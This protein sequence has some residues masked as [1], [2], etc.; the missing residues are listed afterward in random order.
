M[1]AC[2]PIPAPTPPWLLA[3][4]PRSPGGYDCAVRNSCPAL[5]TAC[6]L[7]YY[8]ASYLGHPD[9]AALDRAFKATVG[10]KG[11]PMPADK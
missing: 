3:P 7:G 6:P 10:A 11:P 5:A 9:E 1:T 2:F 8:C 4:R